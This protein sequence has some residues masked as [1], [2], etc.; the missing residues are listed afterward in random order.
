M[1]QQVTVYSKSWCPYCVRA[2]Q[3]LTQLGAGF[4][5]INV[6]QD[7]ARL[8]EMVARSGRRTVPHSGV[9]DTHVGGCDDLYALHR[10]GKLAGLLAGTQE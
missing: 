10:A 9:G 6:E 2:K 3:L 4:E 8:A 1:T 5:D 7:A